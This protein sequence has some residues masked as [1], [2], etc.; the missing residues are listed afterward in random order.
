MADYTSRAGKVG[1]WGTREPVFKPLWPLWLIM[2]LFF[3]I[4]LDIS[5]IGDTTL[6]FS[7][8]ANA[9]MAVAAKK[10]TVNYG[11]GIGCCGC[12]PYV[13]MLI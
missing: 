2:P 4:S 1:N 11:F 7:L 12:T 3:S 8:H 5:D 6:C 13:W 10:S 9:T